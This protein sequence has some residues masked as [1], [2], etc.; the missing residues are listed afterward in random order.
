MRSTI[1]LSRRS[2]LRTCAASGTCLALQGCAWPSLARAGQ[3]TTPGSIDDLD[4]VESINLR[5]L[6]GRTPEQN[7]LKLFRAVT[8]PVRNRVY[9]AGIMTPHLGVL[10]AQSGT[11][12]GNVDSRI[13][14]N[15]LKY[16]AID[17]Q[18]NRLYIRDATNHTLRAIDL[19]SG[20]VIGPVPISKTVGTLVADSKRQTLYL[21]SAE[22]PSF[23]SYDGQTLALQF[24]TDE[25]GDG[26]ARAVLD[27]DED[28][29]YVLD[30]KQ[31]GPQG[32]LFG[33][34]LNQQK[35]AQ[36]IHFSLP[37]GQRPSQLAWDQ[38]NH[39]WMVGVGNRAI[40]VLDSSGRELRNIP[41]PRELALQ[42]FIYDHEN[43]R[44][45]AAF[46]EQPHNGQVNGT[47]GVVLAF[48]PDS[49]RQTGQLRFGR[50]IHS[51][52]LNPANGRVYL[53]NGDAS[54][55]WEIDAAF[56]NVKALRLGDSVEQVVPTEGGKR[57]YMPSR[58]GGNYVMC[59]DV[60]TQTL[61]A[62]EAGTWPIPL[63]ADPAGNRLL[64]LNA[65]DSTISV[66]DLQNGRRLEDTVEVG[67]PPGSTDRLPDL[68]LSAKHNLAF[69]AYPEFGQVGV[70]DLETLQP[71]A[72]ITINGYPTGDAG[73]GPG[74]LQVVVNDAQDR[75]FAFWPSDR[76]MY[77]YAL[78]NVEL[79][80]VSLLPPEVNPSSGS[81]F[82]Q[83]FVDESANRLFAGPVALD[84]T[85]AQP[86]GET[87]LNAQR[88]FA[89][90]ETQN[91]YWASAV[92]RRGERLERVVS[93]HHRD[94][95]TLADVY[96]LGEQAATVAPEYALDPVRKQLY[97]GHMTSAKFDIYR[98]GFSAASGS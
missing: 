81:S 79:L 4:L 64:V 22:S 70:V 29:L 88:V 48:D 95:L 21:T 1:L 24:G 87:L 73:G 85:S 10:D 54:V 65:W 60:E 96:A 77:V 69:A 50:K 93:T 19:N 53:P 16:L 71:L 13:Q 58:L 9:V 23:R 39:R 35:V 46:I 27:A 43:Q 11:W 45:V 28:H 7:V 83:M 36:T 18:S 74:N 42:R 61:E 55:V 91:L 32:R 94:T 25:M 98:F 75:L 17:A 34:D 31:P 66:Y 90:D 68:A 52:N 5:A 8:D 6:L 63:R 20:K 41:L 49:G 59:F 47:Q 3:A 92:E 2:F 72:P 26:I 38:I 76:K 80:N 30:G 84:G 78:P 82:N 33:F 56:Q 86:T 97:V 37:P 44:L 15:S 40:A 12:I 57:L 51:L 67:L 89:L 62:F 14:G